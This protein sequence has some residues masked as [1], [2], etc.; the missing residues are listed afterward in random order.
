MATR[1]GEYLRD[2][3]LGHDSPVIRWTGLLADD[4]GQWRLLEHYREKCLHV[5]GEFSGA[6]L[7]FE[8]S[9]EDANVGEPTS[10]IQLKDQT[11]NIIAFTSPG[12]S[13]VLEN[14]RYVRPKI[15]G[16]DGSTDL[17]LLMVCR[18]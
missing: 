2:V 10:P 12:I 11:G 4:D 9:N 16:G 15:T 18:R 5:F 1:D 13:H 17:S 14:P 3:Q 7:T 8:G 6:I